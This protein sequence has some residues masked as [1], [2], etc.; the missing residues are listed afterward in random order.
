MMM[1]PGKLTGNIG[2]DRP[3]DEAGGR[4]GTK[5]R[6]G[7]MMTEMKH[8]QMKPWVRARRI[9]TAVSEKVKARSGYRQEV[10]NQEH[11]VEPDARARIKI[12]Q[13]QSP[14]KGQRLEPGTR[15]LEPDL[16]AKGARCILNNP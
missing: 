4:S 16:T 5:P 11:S 9:Q 8:G 3:E 15:W 1:K 7:V 13:D 6:I 10:K 12:P 2:Y 14:G